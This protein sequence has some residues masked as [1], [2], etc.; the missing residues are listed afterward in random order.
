MLDAY[1]APT[2]AEH[3]HINILVHLMHVG[4]ERVCKKVYMNCKNSVLKWNQRNWAWEVKQI[5]IECGLQTLWHQD[6]SA[7]LSKQEL[8]QVVSSCLYRVERTLWRAEVSTKPKLRTYRKI[9]QDYTATEGYVH[10]TRTPSHRSMLA[11]LRGGTAPLQ[12][13]IGRYLSTPVEGRLCKICGSGAVED[14]VHFCV[15]CPALEEARAPL[16]RRMEQVDQTFS[17]LSEEDKLIK[18]LHQANEDSVI[19]KHLYSM[20]LSRS[21]L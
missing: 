9:K 3:N 18:I 12:L 10:K 8:K 5:L 20:F 15:E 16:I 19:A 1:K 2:P 13:E 21:L 17:F 6:S 11:R 7:D 14:E 4:D